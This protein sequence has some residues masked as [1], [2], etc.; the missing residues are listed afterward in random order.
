MKLNYIN[1]IFK[2]DDNNNNTIMQST[3]YILL[4]FIFYEILPRDWCTN[5][6]HI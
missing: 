2:D 1:K 6:H 3:I 4:L 5:E